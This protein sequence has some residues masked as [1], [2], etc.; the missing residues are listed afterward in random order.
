MRRT[1]TFPALLV[2]A[3]LVMSGC[4]GG[5]DD[6]PT[7]P[8]DDSAASFEGETVEV[9]A[10]WSG[11]EQASFEQVADVFEEQT[12]ATVTFTSTGDDIATVIGTR[13]QGGDPPDV[14]ILPQPG[15]LAD[16]AGRDAL[17]PLGDD[18]AAAVEEN[19]APVWSELGSVDGELYGVWFKAANKSTVW[20]RPDAFEQAGVEPP[21]SW[22]ELVERAG[23]I[24]DSGLTPVA[25]AGGDG[26]TLTDWFE[27]VYLR[28]AG[29]EKYTQ[30]ANHEIPWTDPTV[31]TSLETLAELWGNPRLISGGAQGALQTSFPQSVTKV[32]GTQDAAL[33]YEGDFVAGV[34]A[35]ETDATV[36][37]DALF[38][39][40]P[41]VD[42][43]DPA[44]V[45][46]GD[47]AVLMQD[48]EVGQAFLE[49]LAGPE[50]P[51]V[52]VGLGGFTTPNQN[53]DLADYP[54][55]ISRQV[56]EQL[57]EAETFRFDL[58]DL[59]PPEFGGTPSQGMWQILQDFLRD[60]S[61]VQQ[62][63][64]KL[65]QAAAAAYGS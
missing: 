46:G 41:A 13:V 12:G 2:G 35:G 9:A 45:G 4:G 40:F 27:N 10:V 47:V 3:A 29:A 38:F 36:G 34:I 43:S 18:V 48:T 23:T 42:G 26:W 11:E 64:Q 52:W 7:S 61:Q 49:F 32:F 15:L 28:V 8:D 50:A 39:P 53:V 63:T 25:I 56:A 44:V 37:E 60:P 30:L 58:S 31:V 5:G 55:D 62:T 24:A 6:E 57:V 14:A 17:I 22:D 16:F 1:R 33:V 21:E 65:E 51:A 54:D 59:A 20:Y 19:Y